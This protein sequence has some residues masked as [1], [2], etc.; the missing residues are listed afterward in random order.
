L[1]QEEPNSCAKNRPKGEQ[2]SSQGEPNLH[3]KEINGGVEVR[4]S[5]AK[6]KQMGGKFKEVMGNV[7]ARI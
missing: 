4:R 1:N 7:I 2:T 6:R 3:R 5:R